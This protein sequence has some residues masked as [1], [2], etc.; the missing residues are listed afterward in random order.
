MSDTAP[1]AAAAAGAALLLLAAPAWPCAWDYDTL[2][3]ERERF[4]E[5]LEVLAGKVLRHSEAFYAWRIEDRL[6]R[7]EE[8]P[9]RLEWLD[10]LVVAYDKT[11]QNAEAIET[12]RRAEALD[13]DR[14]ETLANLGT[15][16]IHGGRLEEGLA[17]VRRAIEVNPDAHFGRERYQAYLVEYVLENGGAADLPLRPEGEERSFGGPAG[18]AAFL[19]AR[20]EEVGPA[21]V[22]G[23]C[24]MLLF[25]NLESPI[26]LEALGDCLSAG[27]DDDAKQLAARAYIKAGDRAG[28]SAEAA[29]RAL[30]ESALSM[31]WGGGDQLPLAA[32]EAE[33]K[34]ELAE[35]DAFRAGIAADEAAWIEAGDDPEARFAE[36]YYTAPVVG[37]SGLGTARL[38]AGL[39]GGGVALAAFLGL[40]VVLRRRKAAA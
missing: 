2:A 19:A 25:G 9:E 26:L 35:G 3:M 29:Y 30:A 32:V 40:V 18:F 33:L 16:L 27:H 23:I 20:D 21:A 28:G 8:D 4:P 38:A 11:G 6:A 10:D 5:V 7:L 12:A 39:G 34:R 37:E 13:P 31:Q 15:V 22:K 14:Y 24:G 17:Y 36:A 1:R